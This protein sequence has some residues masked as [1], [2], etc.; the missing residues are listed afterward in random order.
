MV[1][2]VGVA[3]SSTARYLPRTASVE[4]IGNP[5]SHRI[6]TA[7]R[8]EGIKKFNLDPDGRTLLVI[9]GSLGSESLNRI[10]KELIMLHEQNGLL[11][12][13]QILHAVGINKYDAFLR[14]VPPREGY[15]PHPF[16]YDMPEALAAADLVLCRAG[17][18]TL[19]E[20]TARGLPSIIIPW[21]GAVRNHQYTNACELETAGAAIVLREKDASGIRIAELFRELRSNPSRLSDMAENARRIGHPDAARRLADYILAGDTR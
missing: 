13:W 18:M 7:Q 5:V 10:V 15:F 6:I 20:V 4:L 9:G 21:P 2:V 3:Y 14:E 17:A 1:D 19:A 11:D 8:S 16:I 12:G